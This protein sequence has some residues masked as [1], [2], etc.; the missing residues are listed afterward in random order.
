MTVS[1]RPCLKAIVMAL[2][3][4]RDAL[5]IDYAIAPKD[6]PRCHLIEMHRGNVL[7]ADVDDNALDIPGWQVRGSRPR[8]ID[9]GS[10]QSAPAL[11]GGQ[12]VVLDLDRL[13]RGVHVG[14]RCTKSAAGCGLAFEERRLRR[15]SVRPVHR[16]QIQFRFT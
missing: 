1:T 3:P 16:F 2:P 12:I 15:I 14:T 10:D 4:D 5:R 7:P 11:R 8:L 6:D 9:D 13:A